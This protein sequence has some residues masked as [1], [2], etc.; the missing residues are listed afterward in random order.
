MH[1]AYYH[2]FSFKVLTI[3][4]FLPILRKILQ[5]FMHKNREESS[6][7]FIQG[8]SPIGQIPL[9]LKLVSVYN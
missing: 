6:T 3:S 8:Q 7:D 2:E 4:F 5:F 9:V 1:Y